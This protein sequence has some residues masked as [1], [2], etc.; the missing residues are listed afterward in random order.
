[1]TEQSSK[2]VKR[3]V[4]EGIGDPKKRTWMKY[5]QER[6]ESAVFAVSIVLWVSN[7]LKPS[8]EKVVRYLQIF[9][10]I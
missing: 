3:A 1:M 4:Y 6:L 10:L 2:Y 9:V 7:F 8:L 5:G